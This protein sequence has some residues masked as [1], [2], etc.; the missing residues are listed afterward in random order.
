M[1]ALVDD[2]KNVRMT[3]RTALKKEGFEVAEF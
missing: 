1:I 3:I 2:E